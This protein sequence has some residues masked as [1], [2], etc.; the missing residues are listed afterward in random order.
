MFHVQTHIGLLAGGED[1]YYCY[2]DFGLEKYSMCFGD[3][4][5]GTSSAAVDNEAKQ[6][7]T[8]L[9]E[10][11]E[12]VKAEINIKEVEE[13]VVGLMPTW[14]VTLLS[15]VGAF[16][17]CYPILLFAKKKWNKGNYSCI[18]CR[19]RKGVDCSD[20]EEI[21]DKENAITEKFDEEHSVIR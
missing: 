3:N 2:H 12:K 19:Q 14:T 9:N 10:E 6:V 1:E 17:V 5:N 20:D 4:E 8:V 13:E 21:Q 18:F 11:G 7:A 15:I 16:F